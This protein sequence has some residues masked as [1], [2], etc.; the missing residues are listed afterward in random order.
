LCDGYKEYI[1]K[2]NMGQFWDKKDS[3]DG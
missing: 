3:L 1:Y 2:A